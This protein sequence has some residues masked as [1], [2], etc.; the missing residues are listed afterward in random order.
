MSIATSDSPLDNSKQPGTT[1]QLQDSK[2]SSPNHTNGKGGRCSSPNHT[3]GK[4]GRCS[5]SDM[6]I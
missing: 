3:N 5:C 6:P 2:H 1:Q 4:G